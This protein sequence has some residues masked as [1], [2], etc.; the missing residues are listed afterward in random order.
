MSEPGSPADRPKKVHAQPTKDFFVEM[1]TKDISLTDCILDLVDNAVDGARRTVGTGPNISFNGYRVAINLTPTRFS[2]DDNCGGIL[3]KDAID[4]AFHFG[5]RLDAPDD[6]PG[7]I[8]LYGIGMKRAIFKIGRLAKVVSHAADASYEVLVDVDNWKAKPAE[9]WD[10]DYSDILPES[11]RGTTIAIESLNQGVAESFADNAF[12]ND[13]VKVLS[14][15]YAFILDKGLEITVGA[16][17]V[18]RAGYVLQASD[19]FVPGEDIQVIDGVQISL[20]CGLLGTLPDDIPDELKFENVERYG[21]YV[22]CND[23]VVVAADKTDLTVW[24]NDGFPVWHPQYAGFAGFAFF[25]ANDQRKL[26]W[27]TTK[28]D[29]DDSSAL[30]ARALVRMKELTRPFIEYTN[31]RKGSLDEAKVLER[32][33]RPRPVISYSPSGN[34]TISSRYPAFEQRVGEEEVSISYKRPRKEVEEIRDHESDPGL[35]N[36]DIGIRT[37]RYYRRMELGK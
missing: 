1:I 32:T 37:F 14:R 10:F 11:R 34:R 24:G 27:T 36:K 22:V 5:R 4:Y 12:V 23:R 2:I 20:T 7:G 16:H 6:V 28:R 8:G 9:D 33:V 18:P 21:W 13:L 35:S 29:L 17:T 19:Q 26:P 3:L 15:D 30:Y 31:Q 25:Y